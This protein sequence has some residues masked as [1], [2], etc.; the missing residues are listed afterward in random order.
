[1]ETEMT[2]PIVTM[3]FEFLGVEKDASLTP[4]IAETLRGVDELGS[5]SAAAKRL[6]MGYSHTLY[7]IRDIEKAIGVPILSS[8]CSKGSAL[9]A[10][11][12]KLLDLYDA[13]QRESQDMVNQ[14]FSRL[15][16]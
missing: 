6:R 2:T 9:T 11:G 7:A 16:Q 5:L 4:A 1:M 12:R 15:T 10:E 13:A 8:T 14:G 3:D